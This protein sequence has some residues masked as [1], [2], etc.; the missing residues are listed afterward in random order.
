MRNKHHLAPVVDAEVVPEL[1]PPQVPVST[2]LTVASSVSSSPDDLTPE[3]DAEALILAQSP[4]EETDADRM[5]ALSPEGKKKARTLTPYEIK[6][7][8]RLYRDKKHTQWDIAR[9]LQVNQSSI[10]RCLA[11]YEDTR[12]QAE[13]LRNARAEE[14]MNRLFDKD[15]DA[16]SRTV[17]LKVL[18]GTKTKDG[19]RL[20]EHK[21]QAGKDNGSAPQI[22]VGLKV[23]IE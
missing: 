11:T 20:I 7:V 19:A 10:S 21:P 12:I 9:M 8:L 17:L 1:L 4:P 15:E 18:Q 16:D 3:Q 5:F 23:N 13:L 2:A 14:A 6:K 22:F